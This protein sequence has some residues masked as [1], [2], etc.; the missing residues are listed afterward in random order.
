MKEMVGMRLPRLLGNCIE[1]KE[2]DLHTDLYDLT[3]CILKGTRSSLFLEANKA[4]EPPLSPT[5][6]DQSSNSMPKVRNSRI[7]S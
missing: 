3:L 1:W 5:N 6:A 7:E 2:S 4:S